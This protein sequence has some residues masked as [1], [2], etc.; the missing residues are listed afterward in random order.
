MARSRIQIADT[1][2]IP[3]PHAWIG[4]MQTEYPDWAYDLDRA[5][6]FKGR[7]REDVFKNDAQTPLDVEIGTGNGYFFSHRATQ[8]PQR[9]IVGLE[10]KF[11]PLVQSIRRVRREGAVNARICRYNGRFIDDLFVEGEVNDVFIHHPDPW[12]R[13]KKHK[14]RLI[15]AEF[16]NKLYALQ[17]PGST[18]EFKTDSKEYFLWTEKEFAQTPYKLEKYTLDLHNSEWAQENFK[19]HF[20]NL[21]SKKQVLINYALFR[22]I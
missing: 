8:F 12:T 10:V 21:F 18:L 2:K 15:T 20:E 1:K 22:K 14:K 4:M 17:K 13:A 3:K 19:T 16:L 11:K 7:W 5:P 6:E 9:N